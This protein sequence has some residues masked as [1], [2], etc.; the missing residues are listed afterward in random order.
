MAWCKQ[1]GRGWDRPRGDS[2]LTK[3]EMDAMGRVYVSIDYIDPRTLP[4]RP[5]DYLT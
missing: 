4:Q 5:S 3:I 1:S 2:T